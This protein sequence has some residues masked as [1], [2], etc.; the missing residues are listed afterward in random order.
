MMRKGTMMIDDDA[1]DFDEG[2]EGAAPEGTY[3]EKEPFHHYHSPIRQV[4]FLPLRCICCLS[5]PAS[6]LSPPSKWM[7]RA[8]TRAI[9]VFEIT[10]IV[11]LGA[12]TLLMWRSPIFVVLL[13]A[14][15]SESGGGFN[16]RKNK[17]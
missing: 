1:N 9:L 12:W 17:P 13:I 16:V 6:S 11:S 3:T 8:F 14:K 2:Q 10:S 7:F 5:R 15:R 4:G